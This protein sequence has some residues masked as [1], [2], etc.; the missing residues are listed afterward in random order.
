MSD[1]AGKE[2]PKEYREVVNHQVDKLGWRYRVIGKGHP[3][4]YPADPSRR[5]IGV[6]TTPG[7]HRSLKNFIA[8]VRRAGGEWPPEKER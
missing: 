5:P 3:H 4:L 8:Q 7:D 2:A 6:P 1:R